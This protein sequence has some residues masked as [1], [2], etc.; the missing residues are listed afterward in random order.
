MERRKFIG[1]AGMAAGSVVIGGCDSN[2]EKVAVERKTS[3]AKKDKGRIYVGHNEDPA[4]ALKAAIAAAGGLSFI[5]PGSHVVLKPN[6]AWSRTPQQAANTDPRILTA[7]IEMC[8]AAGAGKI[9]V[10]EHTIDRPAAQVLA[11]S[12]IGAAARNAGAELVYAASD[13][14]FEPVD[15]KSGKLMNR[16][17]LAKA[18]LNADVLINMPKAKHHSQTGLSLGLKNLMGVVFN[19]Q[20]WHSG[21]DLHQYIADYATAV[22]VDLTVMD[23]SRILL[24]NGPKGPGD[25]RDPHEVIV[26]FDPVAV[27]A[28]ACGLF[29]LKPADIG[30]VI[31]AG[32]LGLGESDPNKITVERV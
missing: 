16:D 13:R 17:T 21:P 25:T 9:T 8:R 10:F 23:A 18:V 28:Y 26:S 7:M 22:P 3:A 32:E 29:G 2:N 24:T 12:G 11:V 15:I 20:A 31:K 5:G 6:V 19:R 4:A 30:Y 1:L 14:D 27:D